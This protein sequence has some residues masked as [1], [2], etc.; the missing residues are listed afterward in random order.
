MRILI[1]SY[2]TSQPRG[3]HWLRPLGSVVVSYYTERSVTSDGITA[4]LVREYFLDFS[5]NSQVE[6]IFHANMH[7]VMWEEFLIVGAEFP[8][9]TI[10]YVVNVND[11]RGFRTIQTTQ[12]VHLQTVLNRD[13]LHTQELFNEPRLLSSSESS[14]D[15]EF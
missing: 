12:K 8:E 2:R 15:S 1:N 5:D 4:D 6:T 14:S 9:N 11:N 10:H 3:V 13:S 7:E